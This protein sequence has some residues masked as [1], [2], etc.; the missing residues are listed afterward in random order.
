MRPIK[1]TMQAFG[2]YA[3]KEV[4]DFEKLGTEQIFV[5]SGKTGAGKSTIFDAISFAIFGKA[6]TFDRES[7]SMRSHFATDKE[8]TE[9]TLAFR[10]KD[11]I[12]QISRIPQQEI[13]KQRGNG[14]TT[15]PQK[16]EL[17]ELI[18]DEMK[19]LASSVR[20]V[21]TKMEELIQLN[22]DQ[23]RQILMIPQGEFRELL[24]SDS[25]EKEVILQ[26][27]AH[28]VYY[29][30]VENLLWEKQKQAEIL[31]VEAR[32]K[33]AELAELSLPGVE[34]SGKTTSEISVLQAEA[35]QS[36]Q[37]ILTELENKLSIIRKQTSEAVEKVTLAKEQLLDWQNLDKYTEEI[38]T[39]EIEKDFY[40]AIEVRLEAA[41]RASNLRSQ[42]A[43][44][45]RLKEQLETAEQTEKQVAFEAEEVKVQFSHVKK[46]KEALAEKEAEL[47]INK[48]TLF[49]LEE[50]EPK[51]LELEMISIQKRRAELEWKEATTLLE[52]IVNS[53][54]KIIAELQSVESRLVEINQAELTYLE[55][56]N[57]RT[58]VEA[59]I[60]KEQELVSKRMKMVAW[61]SEKQTEEQKLVQLLAEKAEIETTIEQEETKLQKEQA[62]T[63]A[64]HIHD[65]EACPVCGSDS[66][67]ALAKFGETANLETLEVAKGKL[68][69]K[70]LAITTTEKTISQLEW[71]LNEWVGIKELSL[72]EVQQTLTE[73][74]QL[75]NNLAEQIAQ[76]QAK[77]AQKETIQATLES[78]NNKQ[79]ETITEKNKVALEV[80]K[81]HQ[82]V[83]MVSGKLSYLEQS[84]PTEFRDKVVFE[85]KKKELSE[86]IEAHIKQANQV[87]ALFRQTEKE[88]T[89][90]ESTLQSAQKTT[91]DAKEALQV[92]RE[93]F[94]EA[95]K[96][97]DFLSYDAYK[98]AFMSAEE[99]K[100]QEEKVADYERKRHLAVSR[101][102]DLK[103][104]LQNKQKPNIEQLEFIM[105]E[106]QLELSQSE[107]NTMKQ[108]EFVTKRKELVENYQ[109]SIQT[110]EQ[111]EENYA[112]IGLLADAARGKN[113]RRLTFERYI[114]AMFLDTIIHR[115]NHR[116]SKM[117][118]GRFELQRKMEKAK[119]N[120]QSGLEL[121]VFDEYT[122]LTR[123]VKTLS[124]GE[125][126]KT[127]L[128]LA[129]SLAEVVQEMAGGISLETMFIDEGFGTLD[130][131]SLEAAV[132][133]L[134]ET[135]ENGRLVGIISHVPELKERISAR[136][137]VTATNHG[138]TT[139]FITASS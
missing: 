20:D 95:M 125:S 123:H 82:Q 136:L 83:Q 48:R 1:L 46:Q 87:D 114:L 121:E 63:I 134:L 45:I 43:L 17:Y 107:E 126:F 133:C 42:D 68:H 101:Q 122:G 93:I 64:A 91:V 135:Q 4:I 9:V 131:E 102:A 73:N 127:S 29:E 79:N 31:V 137:E 85:S 77:V 66:H 124:G 55:V 89:R 39:L 128:A 92:Q 97:N 67:P 138:S 25:K 74:I 115:A 72:T 3:K 113:A 139:K 38:A 40:Q 62:A 52:E 90:L 18:N 117:T 88:T 109:N 51:I 108:R 12:Y 104:K 22:V 103:E 98:Q 132:E 44:C 33:V 110:V 37:M 27:L 57:K 14:T 53:E 35:I 75:A 116:L 118:S 81:L 28:T 26:R 130:P 100:I 84:I 13:A 23:F 61:D 99:Q 106:K 15:S 10:L 2:A 16:A 120:V 5:I 59:I 94:K 58:T 8:I 119:G 105:K 7:F 112:D 30:K 78:L 6:N 71:Q 86:K 32:K 19:L 34:V 80:E 60:E 76:L 129:L 96:Q 36:E 11:K 56:I 47:E 49:Q 65:G 70:L 69:E 24:V 41:K 54:Q 111:A 21:N 50:M